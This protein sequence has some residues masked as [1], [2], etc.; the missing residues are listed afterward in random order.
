[1]GDK[2]Q[3]IVDRTASAYEA[4]VLAKLVM[5]YMIGQQFVEAGR[6]DCTLGKTG[7]HALDKM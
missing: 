3:V 5:D 4:P 6:S 2:F 7:G 1:M